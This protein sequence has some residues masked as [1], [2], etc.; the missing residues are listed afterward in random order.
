MY[1]C[2]HF[3]VPE[4]ILVQMEKCC[5]LQE[6]R[7]REINCEWLKM[8]FVLSHVAQCEVPAENCEGCVLHHLQALCPEVSAMC[9]VWERERHCYPVSVLPDVI[10]AFCMTDEVFVLMQAMVQN[11]LFGDQ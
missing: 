1:V 5:F 9:Q 10:K 11:A 2:A 4:L 8:S 6:R 3:S 7:F